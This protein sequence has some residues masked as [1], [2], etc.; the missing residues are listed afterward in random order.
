LEKLSCAITGHRSQRFKFKNDEKAPLCKK[1]KEVLEEQIK[2]HYAKGVRTFY[3]GGAVGVDTWAAEIILRL[4]KTE[5]YKDMELFLAIPFPEQAEKFSS[6]SKNRYDKILSMCDQ[7]KVI[8]NHYS[9]VAHKRR[10][11]FMVDHSQYLIAVYDQDKS[12][13]SGTGQ[14]VNYA[15]KKERQLTFIHPD[16]AETTGSKDM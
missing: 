12:I 16:T 14:T 10:N 11:Y 15:V 4:K 9:A 3:V 8:S 7:K 5:E 2:S 6:G 1:I 13:R